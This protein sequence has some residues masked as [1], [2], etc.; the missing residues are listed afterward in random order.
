MRL[1][2]RLESRT[3]PATSAVTHKQFAETRVRVQRRRKGQMPGE[4]ELAVGVADFECLAS[5]TKC[6]A[7]SGCGSSCKGKLRR[8]H[9]LPP[10]S[11]KHF[12]VKRIGLLGFTPLAISYSQECHR[13]CQSTRHG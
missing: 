11:S 4:E 9:V 7:L 1:P 10:C 5:V 6:I 12:R 8:R 13:P 3:Q 2:W